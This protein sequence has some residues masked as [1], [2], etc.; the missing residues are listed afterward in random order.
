M[1]V[2]SS[3]SSGILYIVATPIGN[4]EDITLRA[5]RILKEVD[6]IASEDTRR[7]KILLNHLK[8]ST[9]LI[10]YYR[11]KEVSRSEQIIDLLKQGKNIALVS[12]AGTPCISDPGTILIDK[13]HKKR[14]QVTPIP[15]ASALTA[16]LCLSGMLSDSILFVGFLPN[17]KSARRKKLSSLKGES[18]LLAFY[19]SPKR[20][21]GSLKDM[22]D[23][24]GDRTVFVVRELTKIHEEYFSGSISSVIKSLSEKNTV[25][26][27]FVIILE[28]EKK[29]EAPE[30]T[31]IHQLIEWYRDEGSLSLSDSVKKISKDIGVSKAKVYQEA[32]KIWE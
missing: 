8:I 2:S 26:G 16:G 14:I 28:G 27:E 7:T 12:D 11:E 13:A 3:A 9:Q 24:L 18:H 22:Y 32:L 6:C 31:D 4:L 30:S 20:V 29:S 5:I 15:G 17:G 19:E 23:L 10:S 1:K 21:I 25:K